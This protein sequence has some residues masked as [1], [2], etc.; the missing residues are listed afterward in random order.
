MYTYNCWTYS[1]YA[2]SFGIWHLISNFPDNKTTKKSSIGTFPPKNVGPPGRK[3]NGVMAPHEGIEFITVSWTSIGERWP[4]FQEMIIEQ[5][6]H[7][8]EKPPLKTRLN[9]EASIYRCHEDSCKVYRIE[10][11]PISSDEFL[12]RC[13]VGCPPLQSV[14]GKGYYLQDWWF[15]Y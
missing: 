13:I 7:Y 10:M 2:W 4:T 5:G 12:D 3:L 11:T 1:L 9:L 8:C 6:S 14:E 15:W